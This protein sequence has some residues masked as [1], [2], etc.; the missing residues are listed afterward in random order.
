MMKLYAC[1]TVGGTRYLK[2]WFQ[3]I[4]KLKPEYLVI[5]RDIDRSEGLE[6]A[7]N[8]MILEYHSRRPWKG[9]DQR[10]ENWESDYSILMGIELLMKDF[11]GS[12]AT[13]FLHVDSDVI[14]SKRAAEVIRGTNWDYLKIFIMVIPRE[15]NEDERKHWKEHLGAFG[16]NSC[17]GLSRRMV[18]QCLTRIPELY[19]KPY[20]VDINL[21][22]IF[23]EEF[24]KIQKCSY[25]EVRGLGVAHYVMGERVVF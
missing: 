23:S 18:K 10:H 4:M 15:L 14:L 1:T 24:R 11:I 13:H 2:E 3:G 9:Y 5:C 12:D 7:E 6:M 21:H 17:F 20:P 8:T 16:D 25:A 22:K 19:N